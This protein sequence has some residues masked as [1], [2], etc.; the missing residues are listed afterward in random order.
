VYAR[1]DGSVA[2]T[3]A[4]QLGRRSVVTLLMV[5]D[6]TLSSRL[7][8]LPALHVAADRGDVRAAAALLMRRQHH[9]STTKVCCPLHASANFTVESCILHV[10]TVFICQL[11]CLLLESVFHHPLT[12]SFHA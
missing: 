8:G 1:Q 6:K 3:V 10:Y 7:K 4:R 5:D 9:H 2:M 11:S 12:L